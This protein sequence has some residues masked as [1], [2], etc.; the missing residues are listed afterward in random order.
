MRLMASRV[1]EAIGNFLLTRRSRWP[2]SAAPPPLT[3]TQKHTCK[4]FLFHDVLCHQHHAS[5]SFARELHSDL[6]K[7]VEREEMIR[8]CGGGHREI[9]SI[10]HT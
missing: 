7:G 2:A 4:A 10:G 9:S 3:P 1:D 6:K 8:E 5:C